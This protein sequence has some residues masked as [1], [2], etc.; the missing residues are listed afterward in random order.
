MCRWS[1]RRWSMCRWSGSR[2]RWRKSSRW[3]SP[4]SLSGIPDSC[5][6]PTA[7]V[8]GL[9]LN[10]TCL[11]ADHTAL[12]GNLSTRTIL[13]VAGLVRINLDIPQARCRTP[14]KRDHTSPGDQALHRDEFCCWLGATTVRT[15]YRQLA[16]Y[17]ENRKALG[18]GA[19][20]LSLSLLGVIMRRSGQDPTSRSSR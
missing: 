5:D 3:S 15:S 16:S 10:A 12:A 20:R 14:T 19:D 11:R 13:A 9:R 7:T 2:H 4:L 18:L 6:D 8:I 1:T 17:T